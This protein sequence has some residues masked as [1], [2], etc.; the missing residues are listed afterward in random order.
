MPKPVIPGNIPNLQIFYQNIR[1]L[2]N[3]T[4]E[5][6]IN[7]VNDVPHI[8]CF[9]EHHL[10]TE[11]IQTTIIYNYNLRAYYCRKHIKCGGVCIF[12]HKSYHFVNIGLDSHCIEQNFEVC[13][14]KLSNG[15]IN[16]CVL[17]LY[18]SP[19]E[20]FDTFIVKLEEILNILFQNQFNLVIRGD[21][22]VSFMTN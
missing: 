6:N 19:S 22:N 3:K 20:N 9:T 4:D 13:T 17:S 15:P 11:V 12:I 8:L 14:I 21:F 7:W 18:R 10:P 5:L 1:S 16:L 2:G